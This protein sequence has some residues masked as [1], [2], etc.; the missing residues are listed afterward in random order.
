[1]L[2]KNELT[3]YGCDMAP[4]AFEEILGDL[5]GVLH[6]ALSIGEL[7]RHPTLGLRYIEAVRYRAECPALPEEMIL[8]RL[9][10]L[11]KNGQE[12]RE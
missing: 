12:S 5:H 9:E 11:R 1:M 10:N 7:L 6:P 3:Q 8:R 4:E 2:L